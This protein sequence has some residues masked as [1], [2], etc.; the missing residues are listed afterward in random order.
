MGGDATIDVMSSENSAV[1]RW[2]VRLGRSLRDAGRAQEE[3]WAAY[4]R[5][6]P[7]PWDE[8]HWE[9]TASGWRL[10][11]SVLPAERSSSS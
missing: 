9:P 8:L 1:V 5:V 11:G 6:D 4:Q 7:L 3:L 10:Y 2:A